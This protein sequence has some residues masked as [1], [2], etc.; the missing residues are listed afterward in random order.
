MHIGG[1]GTNES[2]G[3]IRLVGA[4]ARDE[5]TCTKSFDTCDAVELEAV[6]N[7]EAILSGEK[8]AAWCGSECEI[9]R[10]GV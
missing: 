6:T 3:M 8:V 2:V 7:G 4:A 1:G 9:L 10:C 5:M